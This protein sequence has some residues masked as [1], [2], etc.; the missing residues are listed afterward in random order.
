MFCLTIIQVHTKAETILKYLKSLLF[1]SLSKIER[2]M[3]FQSSQT[4]LSKA[5]QVT[6]KARISRKHGLCQGGHH[7]AGWDN[8]KGDCLAKLDIHWYGDGISCR[9]FSAPLHLHH[10][11]P[12]LLMCPWWPGSSR[13]TWS[14]AHSAALCSRCPCGHPGQV[15]VRAPHCSAAPWGTQD[16]ACSPPEATSL[17][18]P[19]LNQSIYSG[20]SATHSWLTNW[21]VLN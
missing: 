21:E 2:R 4:I 3:G 1:L 20:T 13:N 15:A 16:K 12:G 8:Q 9:T 14:T 6:D 17:A 11:H 10:Q 7:T 18:S 5:F 19:G